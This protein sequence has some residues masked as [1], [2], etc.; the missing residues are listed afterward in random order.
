MS[1]PSRPT[2]PRRPRLRR[3]GLL[4]LAALAVALPTPAR[5]GWDD[6]ED[7]DFARWLRDTG[8]H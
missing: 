8:R 6:F 7:T 2:A 1:L 5:A 3:L 4:A